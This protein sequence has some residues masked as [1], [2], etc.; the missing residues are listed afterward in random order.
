MLGSVTGAVGCSAARAS[1]VDSAPQSLYSDEG[2]LMLPR[3]YREWIQLGTSLGL[4]YGPAAPAEGS[5]RLFDT[6]FVSPAAH[7][8]FLAAGTWPDETVLVL[9]VRRSY[10]PESVQ[11]GS[12]VAGD[13]VAIEAEVKDRPRYGGSG[14]RFFSFDSPS[15]ARLDRASP[16]DMSAPCY[17]CHVENTA[18]D[19]TF[20]Q[21]YAPLFEVAQQLG[22][23]RPDWDPK[24]HF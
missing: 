13:I 14:W 6:V 10:T 11:A 18:V 23:I 1:E 16:I 9:E 19:N 3:D 15:G 24:R 7:A 20:V 2:E 12:L 5:P 21:F 22:T 17:S 8:A 4:T